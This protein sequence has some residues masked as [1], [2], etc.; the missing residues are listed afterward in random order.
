M[1]I[2]DNR[3]IY[4]Q[5]MRVLNKAQPLN[6]KIAVHSY[7]YKANKL[8]FQVFTVLICAYNVGIFILNFLFKMALGKICTLQ[9]L[10]MSWSCQAHIVL[11]REMCTSRPGMVQE[12]K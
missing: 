12:I 7:K 8:L 5:K 3:M 10:N 11:Y 6:I 4:E 1:Y 9:G 2:R